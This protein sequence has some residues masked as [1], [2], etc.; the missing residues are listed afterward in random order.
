MLP[1]LTRFFLYFAVNATGILVVLF[2]LEYQKF[3]L[4]KTRYQAE[5]VLRL[6]LTLRELQADLLEPIRDI[7]TI[8][9]LQILRDY[10]NDGNSLHR[11]RVE[12]E[13]LNFI[14][15][16]EI[17]DQ[18]RFID[19]SGMERVRVNY[20]GSTATAVTQD[21]LQDK[22]QRYYFRETLQL[23]PNTVFVS[24]MDLNI[25]QGQIEQPFK[26]MIRF[27]TPVFND[28]NQLQGI[29]VLNYL[30]ATLLD[31][32]QEFMTNSWGEPMI[33]NS[34]GYWLL[35]SNSEDEWGFMLGNENTFAKRYAETWTYIVNHESGLVESAEGLFIFNTLQPY[36]AIAAHGMA[37]ADKLIT[38]QHWKIVSRVSPQ[39]L[40]YSPASLLKGQTISLAGLLLLVI[41]VSAI[42]AWQRTKYVNKVSALRESEN[43]LAEAQRIAHVGNWVW[44]IPVD[45]LHW[46]EEI[47]RI[48]GR[49]PRQFDASYDAFIMAIHP[50]D[51]E[52]VKQ[53]VSAAVHDQAPYM[54]DHRIVLPDGR[55]RHV[56]ERGAVQYNDAGEPVRM[57]GT[58]HDISDRIQAEELLR[59]KEERFR[60]LA[61]N[62]EEVFWLTAW[63][64][65]RV[66]YVSPA[67]EQVWGFT[68]DQIYK[69][70]MIWV[71][72]IADEYR[73]HVEQVFVDSASKG[74]FDVT[75]LIKRPNGELRWIHDRAFVVRNEQGEV[76]RIAGVAQDITERKHL[77][78]ALRESEVRLRELVQQASDG[79]FIANI[80]G[81]YTD[82]NIA[83]CKLL[84]YSRE[85]I[86]GKTI[87]DLIAPD[88]TDRLIKSKEQL[89]KGRTHVAEWSL[90]HK[91]GSTLPVE[92]SAKILPD[93][94]WQ[95]IVRDIS[96]RKIIEEQLRNYREQLEEMVAQRT[97]ALEASYKEMEAFS[98]SIAHDLRTPL[99]T[100]T[101]F[102]QILDAD[103]GPKLSVD[104]REDLQ[105]II[106]AGKY[107][108]QLIDDILEISRISRAE[109]NEVEVDLSGM[110][111]SIID[112]FQQIHPQRKVEVGIEPGIQCRGDA[113][114]L[115]TALENLLGN[116]WKYTG[117]RTDAQIQFGI[118][119]QDGKKV[120]FVRD[121]GAGFDMQYV[122]KLFKPF[123]RLHNYDEFEGAGIGLASAQ[124]AIQ[125]HNGKIWA[126][127]SP[128]EG[129]TFYFTLHAF[130]SKR[131]LNKR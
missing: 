57:L 35:S 14:Q 40:A 22:S 59:E 18:I 77:E 121:N 24:R 45:K 113:Q 106:N 17:Y 5:E 43:R 71:N 76:Y 10:V 28:G 16:K 29:V 129:A 2:S 19:A 103:A 11:M 98:Y 100:I 84:G 3:T 70:P 75:Y 7:N 36:A 63:P 31:D 48:F 86:I 44:E 53:A 33:V 102:S 21:Q 62:I 79:I 89:L 20:D 82:V 39:T 73:E 1:F 111:K 49:D 67:F 51:R 88:E 120:Y 26:P 87:L 96:E 12:Q 116:A 95:G 122:H 4:E 128:G 64:E 56:H 74:G 123:G 72:A 32:F 52:K 13:F 54:I 109:F 50:D 47:Y 93:G 83:G 126:E 119:N 94:R 25:E 41:V 85:E 127:S 66:L 130:K 46:S 55:V 92:V 108:S 104:E 30:A 6:S 118:M 131:A 27:A 9:A 34:D 61:D 15:Q 69:D 78:H 101:S 42:L 81:Q 60:Q 58:V 90:Q 23:K 8:S 80:D 105:R 99:R 65:N 68:P 124:S 97:A 117:K 38:K 114:L 107:M 112:N 110:A 91:D 125:R 37:P 115:R